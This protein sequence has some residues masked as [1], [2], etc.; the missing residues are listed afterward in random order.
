MV[1]NNHGMNAGL[2]NFPGGKINNDEYIENCNTREVSEE[3]GIKLLDAKTCGRFDI[4]F[5]E[6]QDS[7]I[8]ADKVRVFIFESNNFIGKIRNPILK[9]GETIPEVK[10]FWCDEDKIPFNKMR[11]ND[12]VWFDMYKKE[13]Y[14]HNPVFVRKDEKLQKIILNN[15]P[16]LSK[17]RNEEEMLTKAFMLRNKL[18]QLF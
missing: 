14:V 16:Q 10:A 4:F 7:F 9:D 12:K 18:N 17:E 8:Q 5:G 13:G 1:R 11:D 2:F 3:T 6:P 15:N